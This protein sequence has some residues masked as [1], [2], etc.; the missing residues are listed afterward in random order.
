M[1]TSV[2]S[3]RIREVC[4]CEMIEIMMV[5]QRWDFDRA[6]TQ[7]ESMRSLSGVGKARRGC[8]KQDRL[9]VD[10]WARPENALP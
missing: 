7:M 8:R 9:S 10:C 5:V 1:R 6:Y 3:A 2:Q 4:G